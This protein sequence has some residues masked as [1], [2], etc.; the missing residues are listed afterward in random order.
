LI[1]S[2]RRRWVERLFR[3]ESHP[4]LTS[5]FIIFPPLQLSPRISSPRDPMATTLL[6]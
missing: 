4:K 2:R 6:P 3:F 1:V 5:C